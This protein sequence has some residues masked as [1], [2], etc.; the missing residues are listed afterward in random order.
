MVL[1]VVKEVAKITFEE[2]VESIIPF[3]IPLI[4]TLLLI[5]YV[6]WLVMVLPN[7]MK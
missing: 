6:P 1:F 7:L 3:Y 2:M 5:T 4:F